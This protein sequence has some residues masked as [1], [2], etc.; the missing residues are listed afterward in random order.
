MSGA[1]HEKHHKM[2]MFDAEF[3]VHVRQRVGSIFRGGQATAQRQEFH[4]VGRQKQREGCPDRQRRI[5][6]RNV[7]MMN[8]IFHHQKGSS[9]GGK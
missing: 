4:A 7:L 2:M 1:R 3:R 9:V 6:S 8:G 5:M